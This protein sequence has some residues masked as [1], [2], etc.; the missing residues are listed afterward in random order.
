MAFS[1]AGQAASRPVVPVPGE[2]TPL[3][4]G[5]T[6]REFFQARF[7]DTAC[8]ADLKRARESYEALKKELASLVTGGSGSDAIDSKETEMDEARLR[9]LERTETCGECAT[10]EIEQVIVPTAG[11]SEIWY[12]SDGSCYA[13]PDAREG[14]L[15]TRASLKDVLK[16]SKR[17]GGFRWLLE[18]MPVDPDSGALHPEIR[19]LE[20]FPF[21]AFIALRGVEVLG[22]LVAY[23]QLFQIRW[24]DKSEAGRDSTTIRYQGINPPRGFSPPTVGDVH[25]SGRITPA[26]QM[27]V[28]KTQAFWHLTSD[29]YVRYYTAADFGMSVK[30]AE[31]DGRRMLL[32]TLL[33]LTERF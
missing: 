4:G 22:Q 33:E 7:S 25:A 12:V 15:K 2:D 9:L 24:E 27:R 10:H 1:Q 3:F 17:T 13:G 20:K 18:F 26:I 28:S 23:T 21:T 16:Y 8:R 29:G 31:R 6:A 30:F 32:D 19:T 14:F 5:K 11:R